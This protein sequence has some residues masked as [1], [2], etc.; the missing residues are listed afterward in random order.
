MSGN[1]NGVATADNGNNVIIRNHAA[2][3]T[4]NYVLVGAQIA[5]PFIGV[6][7]TITNVNPW[8]NFSF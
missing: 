6:S 8:A 3:N 2:N 4:T 1:D 7:G 5:G